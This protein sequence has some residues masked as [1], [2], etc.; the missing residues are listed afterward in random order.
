MIFF[1]NWL[2][3]VFNTTAPEKLGLHDRWHRISAYIQ[4]KKN[5]ECDMRRNF[6]LINEE[7]LEDY[8][9][10][11]NI[12][13][14]SDQHLS[15]PSISRSS[16]ELYLKDAT[17]V[18]FETASLRTLSDYSISSVANGPKKIERELDF[19]PPFYQR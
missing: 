5:F 4:R 11:Q 9:E 1:E 15:L 6:M 2:E 3:K 14:S 18:D 19:V 7:V 8:N 17:S 12:V 13:P 16:S 10:M